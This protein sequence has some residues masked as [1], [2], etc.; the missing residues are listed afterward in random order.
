MRW[1]K[2]YKTLNKYF[3]YLFISIC[4]YLNC[5]IDLISFK[6]S[7]P[8]PTSEEKHSQLQKNKTKLGF[9]SFEKAECEMYYSVVEMFQMFCFG[10]IWVD[11]KF[12]PTILKCSSWF[13][14]RYIPSLIPSTR[15]SLYHSIKRIFSLLFWLSAIL[16]SRGFVLAHY[17][18]LCQ[19]ESRAWIL[20][21]HK[22]N[23]KT[24]STLLQDSEATRSLPEQMSN[25]T[26]LN[27]VQHCQNKM[28]AVWTDINFLLNFT[29][30]D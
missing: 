18:C 9:W 17:C 30:I 28:S 3:K 4:S 21:A 29:V 2:K 15:I 11:E 20:S 13:S 8:M 12:P 26:V 5:R 7:N 16:S 14:L 23:N 27:I 19:S 6:S 24:W 25:A 10:V 22:V 1:R